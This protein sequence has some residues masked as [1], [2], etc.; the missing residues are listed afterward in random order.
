MM[1]HFAYLFGLGLIMLTACENKPAPV[2]TAPPIKT[3]EE[4]LLLT[5]PSDDVSELSAVLKEELFWRWKIT[6][7]DDW[8]GGEESSRSHGYIWFLDDAETIFSFKCNRMNLAARLSS[9]GIWQASRD[10]YGT[11]EAGCQG[12]SGEQDRALLSV[13]FGPSKVERIG[14]GLNKLRFSSAKHDM[15]IERIWHDD[16]EKTLSHEVLQGEWNVL[17]FDDYRPASRLNSEG[18][19]SAYIDF[20]DDKYSPGHLGTQ[21]HIGCNFSGNIIQLQ[22]VK[23]RFQLID[24]NQEFGRLT[25]QK[26]CPDDLQKRDEAFFSMMD[27]NPRLERLGEMRLRLWTDKHELILERAHIGQDRDAVRDFQKLHG[28]WSILS[29]NKAGLGLGGAYYA[30]EPVV[31]SDDKIQYGTSRPYLKLPAIKYGKIVGE[32]IGD[33]EAYD[34]EPSRSFSI[35]TTSSEKGPIVKG[36]FAIC[37]V[38][39]TLTGGSVAELLP[40]PNSFQLTKGDY[41][42]VLVSAESK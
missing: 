39:D 18:K 2:N 27:N 12:E 9:E 21:S 11:T 32:L 16:A 29:V 22:E 24:I 15:I 20:Y 35:E 7:L 10:R 19:R 40:G 41:R 28:T 30:P 8:E 34:C 6:K 1:R 42:L 14:E 33:F 13:M 4:P 36:D 25:T 38:L 3:A 31:I 26:G 17:R 5:P 37:L 23:S